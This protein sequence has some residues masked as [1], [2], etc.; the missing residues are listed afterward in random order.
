MGSETQYT[1]GYKKN[2]VALLKLKSLRGFKFQTFQNGCKKNSSGS[3]TIGLGS[4]TI[5]WGSETWQAF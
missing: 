4:E 5:V 2:R 3:E 1:F